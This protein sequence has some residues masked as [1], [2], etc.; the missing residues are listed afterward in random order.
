MASD[1]NER[2]KQELDT[3]LLENQELHAK[4]LRFAEPSWWMHVSARLMRRKLHAS[5]S[6]LVARST[7]RPQRVER[8]DE[9]FAPSFRPYEVTAA[10]SPS[11]HRPRILHVIA[12]SYTGG[13]ARLVVDLVEHLS[14]RFEQVVVVRDVP[15]RPHYV[16]LDLHE[17]PEL[18]S[19]RAALA[20]LR[21]LRPELIHVHF[22]GHH[23]HPYSEADWRWY[24][25]WFSAAAAYGAP[26]VEN[27]NIP[28]APYLSDAVSRY[29]FVS[30]YVRTIFG[31]PDASNVTIY[32]GSDFSRFSRQTGALPPA[33]RIGMVYRLEK[34]K[35]DE[36][37]IDIFIEVL[38]RR[39]ET[40]A[41]IVG[42]GRFR[43]RYRAAVSSAGL[44]AAVTFTTYVAYDDLPRFYEQM[45]IFVAPPHTESF[46][47]VVP[48]AMNT[49]IPV[50][51]YDVGALPEILGENGVFAPAGDV[52]ALATK[53]VEL[54]DD[55]QRCLDIGAANRERA[56]RLFSIDRM[57]ADYRQL[58][59]ELLAPGDST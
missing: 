3:A 27:I 46:G 20:L 39:P 31:S 15:P 52:N 2:L 47:H 50:A 42:G 40:K 45:A 49:G 51:A 1:I 48:L 28:V 58:Y 35:L 44:D 23:R 26:V 56:Q 5:W 29:V 6:V 53:I 57:I 32:P 36:T 30:D 11:H 38:R 18:R 21:R 41:L 54:L 19:Q 43:E 34:D 12:N 7:I 22:L 8:E 24:H 33:G 25:R 16:G 59:D 14:G 10:P 17:V 37:A 4:L 9:D 55:R 13:S